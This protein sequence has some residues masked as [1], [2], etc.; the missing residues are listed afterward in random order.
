MENS[1]KNTLEVN[2]FLASFSLK[3]VQKYTEWTIKGDS[4]GITTAQVPRL[5]DYSKGSWYD[6]DFESIH[7]YSKAALQVLGYILTHLRWNQDYLEIRLKSNLSDDTSAKLAMNKTSFYK[8]VQE[9]VAKGVIAYRTG[10]TSTY[11]I[12][13]ALFFH[14]NRLKAFPSHISAPNLVKSRQGT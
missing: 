10:R 14:G 1:C 8:G 4:S 3:P 7:L 11:W 6:M 13:P 12:N 5:V 2:P 9:L